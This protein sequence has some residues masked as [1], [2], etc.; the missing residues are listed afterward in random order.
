M[1]GMDTRTPAV[2][3]ERRR[4]ANWWLGGLATLGSLSVVTILAISATRVWIAFAPL[5]AFGPLAV[6][7]WHYWK[8]VELDQAERRKQADRAGNSAIQSAMSHPWIT[9]C[10]IAVPVILF[11]IWLS[12]AWVGAQ[13]DSSTQVFQWALA[14]WV[15]ISAI[16]IVLARSRGAK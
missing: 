12:F 10:A 3:E 11:S 1:S 2:M 13:G 16:L 15:V 9:G 14:A 4:A 5:F 7:A 8:S 6:G